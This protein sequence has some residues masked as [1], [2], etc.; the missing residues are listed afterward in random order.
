MYENL[1][2]LPFGGPGTNQEET[3]RYADTPWK[4][5][6]KRKEK[7]YRKIIF[8]QYKLIYIYLYM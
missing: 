7:N 1:H 2:I 4:L 3:A 6:I 5:Y 8:E